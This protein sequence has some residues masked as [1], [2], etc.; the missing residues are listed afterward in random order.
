MRKLE[1]FKEIILEHKCWLGGTL[2]IILVVVIFLCF[3]KIPTKKQEFLLEE[4]ERERDKISETEEDSKKESC[5]FTVDIKGEVLTPGLYKLP[6]NSRVQDIINAAGGITEMAD[7]SVLNLSQ[8]I[9]DE[10]V[11]VVYSKAQVSN[12]VTTKKE[13]QEKQIAC[14]KQQGVK[15]DACIKEETV[16]NPI[17]DSNNMIDSIGDTPVKTLVSLNTASKI[18]LTTLPGIGD[19]KAE[20]IIKYR[21]EHGTYKTIEEVKNVKGIGDKIF[22]KIKDYITV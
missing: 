14:Q 5:Y 9:M 16:V 6:C 3:Q 20:L 11:V 4:I 8:K 12:F 19:S 22:E 13:E 10:M 21:Q 17:L 1:N 15:N 2:C 18:E 7:T